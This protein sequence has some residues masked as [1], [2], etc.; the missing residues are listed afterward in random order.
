[1]SEVKLEVPPKTK[2]GSQNIKALDIMTGSQIDKSK[3]CI[4]GIKSIPL[5]N[6]KI[7][8]IAILRIKYFFVKPNSESGCFLW[9]FIHHI[10]NATAKQILVNITKSNMETISL[11]LY[12]L[13]FITP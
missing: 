7:K 2:N 1:M 11:P 6:A 9:F 12:Q 13:I 8:L 3:F 4:A 5:Q 10:G